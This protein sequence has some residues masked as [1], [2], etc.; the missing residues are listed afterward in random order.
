MFTVCSFELM[1]AHPQM[2]HPAVVVT[3]YKTLLHT[4]FNHFISKLVQDLFSFRREVLANGPRLRQVRFRYF[5]LICYCACTET[6]TVVLL[7]L[8]LYK[9]KYSAWFLT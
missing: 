6:A 3:V 2:A 9:I 8:I 7:A 5:C 1:N 4:L